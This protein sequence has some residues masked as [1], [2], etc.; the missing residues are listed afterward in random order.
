MDTVFLKLANNSPMP[1]ALESQTMNPISKR[2]DGSMV[3]SAFCSS[4]VNQMSTRNSSGLS[5][6][7][8]TLYIESDHQ[9]FF[10][11]NIVNL[12]YWFF[13]KQGRS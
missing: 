11:L 5:V 1:M 8:L 13:S 7:K 6:Q 3:D 9:E 2:L 4:D 10:S 12:A